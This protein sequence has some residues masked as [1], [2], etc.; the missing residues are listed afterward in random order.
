VAAASGHSLA[1]AL[2]RGL[3]VNYSVNEQ[4]AGH[5][6]I[7]L[8]AATAHRLGISGPPA[9]GLPAGA[10]PSLVIGQAILVTTKGGHSAVRIKFS[11]RVAAHLRHVRK[12]TLTLR[13]IVRNAATQNPQSATVLS[14]FVLQ[15]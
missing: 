3:L 15:R 12:V 1:Q 9:T 6:Q 13:L 4:V 14:T 7:L 8:D 11:K 5:F 2:R 10:A